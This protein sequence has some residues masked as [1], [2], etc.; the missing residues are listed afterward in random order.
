MS[1]AYLSF[2]TIV[3]SPIAVFIFAAS[4]PMR[5]SMAWSTGRA[6]HGIGEIFGAGVHCDWVLRF[7]ACLASYALTIS[8]IS[9]RSF[10]AGSH[11]L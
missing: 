11:V 10:F 1:A 9:L 5:A 8:G 2:T 7:F 6:A 4:F 3:N